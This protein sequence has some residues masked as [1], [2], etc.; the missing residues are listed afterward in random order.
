VEYARDL[1]GTDYPR[2]S[3]LL[4]EAARVVRPDGVIGFLHFILPATPPGCDRVRVH[5][6]TAGPNFR[7]RA[8]TI[9]RKRGRT[10]PFA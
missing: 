4:R 3:H 8:F 10:L 1:Y 9:F 7:I 5:G 2:P 6:I